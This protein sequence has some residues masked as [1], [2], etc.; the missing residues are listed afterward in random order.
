MWR[1]FAERSRQHL[2]GS[3]IPPASAD[4]LW[5]E[6]PVDIETFCADFLHEPLYP[7]QLKLAEALVGKDPKTWDTTYTEALAFWGMGSGKDRTAAK[8]MTYLV[9][10]LL[11]LRHP[12]QFLGLAARDR[13]DLINVAPTAFLAESVFFRELKLM[14]LGAKNPKTGRNWFVEHGL[15]LKR[16][17]KMRE[18]NFPKHITAYSRD[19]Q[20]FTALGFNILLA[21]MDEVG[22]FDPR[23]AKDLYDSLRM[24]ARSRFPGHLKLLLLS[25]KHS[26]SDYMV[27]RVQ[28]AQRERTAYVDGPR[29]SWDVN[30]KLKKEQYHDEYV[31]DPDKAQQKYECTGTRA[32]NRFFTYRE[33][34]IHAFTVGRVE[35]PVIGEP[36]SV[37]SLEDL[38]FKPG[39]QPTANS[40]FLHVD[41]AKGQ[42]DAAGLA[43]GHFDKTLVAVLPEEHLAQLAQATGASTEAI[44]QQLGQKTG[45]VVIDLALQLKAPPGREILFDEVVQFIVRLSKENWKLGQVSFDAWQSVNLIQTLRRAGISA[46]EFSVTKDPKAYNALKALLYQGILAC[47]P[48]PILLRELEELIVTPEGKIDHPPT[49]YRRSREDGSTK[50]SKDLADAVAGCAFLCTKFGKSNFDFG[51]LG[52]GNL[53]QDRPDLIKRERDLLRYESE[54]LVRRGEKPASWYRR[55]PW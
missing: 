50:G 53:L 52:G 40:Y 6:E 29:A 34:L 28:E 22:A 30:P 48:Q 12:Q 41:L 39:F 49:S 32:E 25:A 10:K 36:A 42:Q 46:Q 3:T 21:I 44:R 15:H 7:L 31:R 8:I 14:V 19:G 4:G 16:D 37:T 45:G 54:E 18:I 20:E 11:C 38:Q 1:P 2:A 35:H 51:V 43:L 55:F 23:K 17:I 27:Q 9:Y 24:T 33:H 26:D 47:H 5:E 13:I